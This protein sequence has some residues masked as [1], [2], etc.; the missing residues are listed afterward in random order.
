MTEERLMELANEARHYQTC[1]E[2]VERLEPV[3]LALRD[4]LPE[5]QRKILEDYISAWEELDH[6]LLLL[7]LKR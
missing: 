7:A 5:L 4:S 3:Y 6:S 2:E 1:L